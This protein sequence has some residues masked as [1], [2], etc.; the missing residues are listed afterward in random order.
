MIDSTRDTRLPSETTPEAA[1]PVASSTTPENGVI[2]IQGIFDPTGERLLELKPARRY[3]Y[4]SG[5]IPNQPSG[6]YLVKVIYVAGDV[7]SVWFDA[8]VADDAGRTQHGFFEVTVPLSGKIDYILITDA[9]GVRIFAR[10]NASEI[11][12]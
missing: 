1:H 2:V 7:T 5:P 4:V 12:P 3:S 8:L 11:I 10:I 6:H 9:T